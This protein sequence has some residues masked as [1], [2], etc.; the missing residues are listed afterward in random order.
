MN[1]SFGGDDGESR[2]RDDESGSVFL[3]KMPK[4]TMSLC[5]CH[6]QLSRLRMNA[7]AAVLSFH[8]VRR[9]RLGPSPWLDGCGEAILEF[10]RVKAVG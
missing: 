8:A 10:S 1:R 6:T 5:E 2:V 7:T 4:K 9:R 3:P